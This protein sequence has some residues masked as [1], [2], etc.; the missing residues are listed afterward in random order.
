MVCFFGFFCQYCVNGLYIVVVQLVGV[1]W[2]IWQ[3]VLDDECQCYCRQ[4]F[5]K[6]Y[7]LL[8]VLVGY[9]IKV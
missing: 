3:F 6:E 7:L 9:V 2:F 8:V 4:F 5:D 1:G